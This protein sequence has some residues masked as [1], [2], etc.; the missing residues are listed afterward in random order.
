MFKKIRKKIKTVLFELVPGRS[1]DF[2]IV[3]AQKAGTTS[4]HRYLSLHP[5]I[6]G[7]TQKEIHYFDKWKRLEKDDYW[8]EM[9][10]KSLNYAKKMYFE[11]TPC[12]AYHH[13]VPKLLFDYKPTLKIIFVL[14]EPIDRAYSAW[15]MSKEWCETGKLKGKMLHGSN[16]ILPFRDCLDLEIESIENNIVVET[17]IDAEPTFIRRGLYAT[18]IERYLK[19]FRQD[20]MLILG[21]SDLIENPFATLDR[22]CEFLGAPQFDF[23]KVILNAR[24]VRNDRSSIE[25]QDYEFLSKIFKK[26]NERLWNLLG[27]KVNW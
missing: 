3:G 23:S 19:Y 4:L 14:R 8:Y 21:F 9:H 20:Q 27:C 5:N 26:E 7:T 2:L 12:Y 15:K 11:T 17:N 1:P 13:F 18:Q 10:F 16:K 6:R 25:N 22:I 24:N